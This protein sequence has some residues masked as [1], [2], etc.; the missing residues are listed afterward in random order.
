MKFKISKQHA[1][2]IV[3]IL[4]FFGCK[5]D[6]TLPVENLKLS[7]VIMSEYDEPVKNGVVEFVSS[8]SGP[9]TKSCEKSIEVALDAEG[10]FEVDIEGICQGSNARLEIYVQDQNGKWLPNQMLP[11]RNRSFT[12]GGQE[13][14]LKRYAAIDIE[15]LN[16]QKAGKKGLDSG[17]LLFYP[18]GFAYNNI[19]VDFNFADN[20]FSP[21]NDSIYVISRR[22]YH[23][24]LD[25]LNSDT[26]SGNFDNNGSNLTVVDKK[27]WK[28]K[29]LSVNQ[30]KNNEVSPLVFKHAFSVSDYIYDFG[31][32]FYFT[33]DKV[34]AEKIINMELDKTHLENKENPYYEIAGFRYFSYSA[35]GKT[36]IIPIEIHNECV[37]PN[38]E[39]H[40]GEN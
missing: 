36:Q 17:N 34:A 14:S 19:R 4:L 24:Y 31:E 2:G 27:I 20:E 9:K 16:S 7:G 22:P 33:C 25:D 21:S 3:L 30:V 35:P 23:E 29:K 28:L 10:A 26:I 15:R 13:R 37:F 1:F 38:Y 32:L 5:N 18:D 40:G 39:H 8:K 6:E 12:Q 11:P